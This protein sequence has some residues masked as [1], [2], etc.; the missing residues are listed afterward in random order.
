MSDMSGKNDTNAMIDLIKTRRSVRKFGAQPVPGEVIDA[1]LDAALSAPSASNRQSWHFTAITN[2]DVI[3]RIAASVRDAIEALKKETQNQDALNVFGAYSGYFTFFENAPLVFVACFTPRPNYI[4]ALTGR[5]LR[6]E[7]NLEQTTAAGAAI[8]NLL[9][10]AHSLG[11]G[12][13]WMSGPLIAE[14]RIIKLLKLDG[15]RLAAVI[16]VGAAAETPRQ[17]KRKDVNKLTARIV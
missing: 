8:Q 7:D 13:C 12:A 1:L 15:L 17:P 6:P 5:S 11:Y 3:G 10:A 14:E 9:L 2:L 4:N 16:P